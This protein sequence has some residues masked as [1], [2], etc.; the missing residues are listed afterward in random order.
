[1]EILANNPFLILCGLGLCFPAP[2][3]VLLAWWIGR[4]GS[5]VSIAWRG[6]DRGGNPN[7]EV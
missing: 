3:P 6:W 4:R 2:V 5:P 1:M 7:Q